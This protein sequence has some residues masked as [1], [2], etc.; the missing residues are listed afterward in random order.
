M[1]T[2]INNIILDRS[3]PQFIRQNYPMFEAF[4]A[5]YYEWM[6]QEGQSIDLIK[7]LQNY[8][9]IDTTLDQFIAHFQAEYFNT[10]PNDIKADKAQLLKYIRDFYHNKGNPASFAFL[11][12]ILFNEEVSFYYPGKDILR[13]SDGKWE[14]MY[15]V[16]VL[17][18]YTFE[19]SLNLAVNG[20]KGFTS[21][22]LAVVSSIFTYNQEGQ[23]LSELNL[24]N[25]RG[26]F[27]PG[28][29]LVV[30]NV[31]IADPFN[32]ANNSSETLKSLE[33]VERT[34]LL[35]KSE[36]I[37]NAIWFKTGGSITSTSQ[38]DPLSGSTAEQFTMTATTGYHRIR[39]ELA[40][41][42][43]RY[44]T[45]SVYLKKTSA[46]AQNLWGIFLSQSD[47]AV[48][49]FSYVPGNNCFA[50]FDLNAH[51]VYKIGTNGLA[52]HATGK[53]ESIGSGWYRCSVSG[54]PSS[55][56]TNFISVNIT[57]VSTTSTVI[58]DGKHVIQVTDQIAGSTGYHLNIWG[59]QLE[60][61]AYVTNYMTTDA[62]PVSFGSGGG[63][64]SIGD[65]LT[66]YNA[67]VQFATGVVDNVG[68][69]PVT[70]FVINDGGVGYRGNLRQISHFG[71]VPLS[72]TYLGG[73]LGDW[74]LLQT[75][76]ANPHIGTTLLSASITP[77]AIPDTGD[78]VQI[79]DSPETIGQG[80]VG[81][82]SLVDGAGTILTLD[83]LST[84]NNAYNIP[85]GQVLSATGSGADIT[86]TGG[87]GSITQVSLDTFPLYIH[88][89]NPDNDFTYNSTRYYSI[90]S[91][92]VH[93]SGAQFALG[94]NGFINKYRGNW[95]NEDGFLN[96]KIIQDSYYFQDLSYVLISAIPENKWLDIVDKVINP[97]GMKVFGLM[98]Q[99]AEVS[100]PVTL[101][102]SVNINT[103]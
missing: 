57:A 20:I 13:V 9:Q 53:M 29:K 10:I 77:V 101:T 84:G 95:I 71:D 1:T 3:I 85:M 17:G 68:R 80:A 94:W 73:T 4:I 11:F 60:K 12:R 52:T 89:F 28:E 63:G 91:N 5:A 48:V 99:V 16:K 102:S 40:I 37:D 59:A 21:G 54:I 74:P 46:D 19:P 27:I 103:P 2:T 50:I 15:T 43:N 34:N 18:T 31:N 66:L 100:N 36:K 65:T 26:T 38:T 23:A 86:V 72:A 35:I 92:S 79:T 8:R 75:S 41:P 88:D 81:V 25:I 70:G 62:S 6:E 42:S 44:Y 97:A 32:S 30:P 78:V 55:T 67:G 64:Y 56:D 45:F 22:A 87:G 33:I 14:E 69:G 96:S 82:V 98:R 47:S 7:N 93:G 49:D 39:Q 76:T 58:I 51:T 83:L 90:T 24:T 61:S